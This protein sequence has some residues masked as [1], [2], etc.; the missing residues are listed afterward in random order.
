MKKK[1]SISLLT[2]YL[3]SQLGVL[4]VYGKQGDNNKPILD[5]TLTPAQIHKLVAAERAKKLRTSEGSDEKKGPKTNLI[6]VYE[7]AL[8]EDSKISAASSLLEAAR[9]KYEADHNKIHGLN[10][11]VGAGIYFNDRSVSPANQLSVNGWTEQIGLNLSMPLFNRT[12]ELQAEQSANNVDI[13]ELNNEVAYQGY[14]LEIVRSYLEV[15]RAEEN[16][17]YRNEVIKAAKNYLNSVKEGVDIGFNTEIEKSDAEATVKQL[18]AEKLAI[19]QRL[20]A[21]QIHINQEWLLKNVNL[22]KLDDNLP[23]VKPDLGDV[24]DWI[25]AAKSSNLAVQKAVLA[26][27]G[28][29]L[30]IAT[31]DAKFKPEVNLVSN[32]GFQ[33]TT[34]SIYGELQQSDSSI[35]LSVNVPIYDG[36]YTPSLK[37]SLVAKKM[38]NKYLHIESMKNAAERAATAYANINYAYAIL[39][40]RRSE[41][42]SR[43]EA[44]K[45]RKY[46]WEDLS[47][48]PVH[49]EMLTAIRA[50]NDAKVNWCN[51]RYDL[52]FEQIKLKD[53]V[54]LL[55]I[56]DISNLNKLLEKK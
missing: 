54:G 41:L 37:K 29:D 45:G 5:T 9:L 21:S 46:A 8:A 27:E 16:I 4:P 31:A 49:Y 2:V 32:V 23:V 7:M 52:I 26:I 14:I 17:K 38:S 12:F 15:I 44:Y 55:S 42:K 34:F 18:E 25:N 51:A 3:L 43:E 35:G 28:S 24:E 56:E 47:I 11:S 50:L 19:M 1:K 6:E 39:E 33:N 10:A 30:A 20:Q 48:I 36:G 22:A 13:E 53:S 40:K